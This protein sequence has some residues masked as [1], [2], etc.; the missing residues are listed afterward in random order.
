MIHSRSPTV[1]KGGAFLL[2]KLLEAREPF[3]PRIFFFF[4]YLKEN[5]KKEE[6][7]RA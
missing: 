1:G 6:N 2:P 3:G 4:K 5:K 7:A